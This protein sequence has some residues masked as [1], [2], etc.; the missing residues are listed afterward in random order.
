MNKSYLTL[1][2]AC[3]VLAFSCNKEETKTI[4]EQIMDGPWMIADILEDT[5]GDGDRE[6]IIDECVKDNVYTFEKAN[7]LYADNGNNICP[8]EQEVREGGVWAYQ[9]QAGERFFTFD[10]AQF[11]FSGSLDKLTSSQ[12]IVSYQ[13]M[14]ATANINWEVRFER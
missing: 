9:E 6:S 3:L 7:T 13:Y 4:E 5:D 2:A 10:V 14:D 8:D 12:L 1:I 11:V